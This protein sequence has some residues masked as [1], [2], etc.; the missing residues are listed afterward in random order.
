[1]IAVLTGEAWLDL[2]EDLG[3]LGFDEAFDDDDA[4]EEPEGFEGFDLDLPL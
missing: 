1:V 2:W 4:S 3:A